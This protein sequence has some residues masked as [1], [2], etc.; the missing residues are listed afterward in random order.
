M[1]LFRA[2]ALFLAATALPAAA[3]PLPR[4]AQPYTAVELERLYAGQ[5]A[6][7]DHSLAFF[8]PDH[9]IKGIFRGR[10]IYWGHWSVKGNEICMVNQGYDPA[11]HAR[12][13]VQPD[14]WKWWHDGKR[15]IT[16]YSRPFDGSLPDLQDGYYLDEV[17]ALKPGDLV[18][19]RF[20]VIRAAMPG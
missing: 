18:S 17:E 14:C 16:L 9:R 4:G 20:D 8:A 5:T 7:W 6:V 2:F 12:F 10:I 13:Q 3:G 1:S 11:R 15:A 19:P